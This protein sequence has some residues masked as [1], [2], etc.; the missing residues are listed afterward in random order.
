[1]KKLILIFIFIMIGIYSI[2]Q[3]KPWQDYTALEEAPAEGDTILLN[4]VSDTTDDAT[5]T[6]K[7]MTMLYLMSLLEGALTS[8][9]IH[10]DNLP[11][12]P[13]FATVNTGQ[14]A[15]ELY[16]MDQNVLTTS[17]VIHNTTTSDLIYKCNSSRPTVVVFGQR[18][19]AD[20]D[21]WNPT[22]ASW[23]GVN[24]NHIVKQTMPTDT[25]CIAVNNP[26]ACCLSE[27]V[28]REAPDDCTDTWILVE[29]FD[30]NVYVDVSQ[31]A[32]NIIPNAGAI[33]LTAA[34]MNSVIY[35]TDA[36]D[37]VIPDAQCDSGNGRWLT[38]ISSA[39]HLNSIDT[40][41]ADN[42]F[43]LSDGTTVDGD[44][45]EI[46]LGSAIGS[47]AT[48]MCIA[49]NIWKVTGEMGG[50]VTDGGADD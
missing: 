14:G 43:L 46:D 11:S 2:C 4:D 49:A 15:N 40:A 38:V 22:G 3:A 29:D 18:Y 41:D 36:G 47:Q 26:H 13:T 45:N 12:A 34:Q 9:E 42:D 39:A 17:D 24:S 50:A 16:D 30:G 19:C 7:S 44:A 32:M 23:T 1:M 10:V 8:F 25:E 6:V 20:G 27:G 35:A 5:G 28:D 31:A 48:V 21:S 33:N 37:I